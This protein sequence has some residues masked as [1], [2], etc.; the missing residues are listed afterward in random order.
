MNFQ[1]LPI[2]NLIMLHAFLHSLFFQLAKISD[3][4]GLNSRLDYLIRILYPQ[5]QY[6]FGM[7]SKHVPHDIALHEL[8]ANQI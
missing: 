2:S 6:L 4:I 8:S 1:K 3:Q 5:H 7:F